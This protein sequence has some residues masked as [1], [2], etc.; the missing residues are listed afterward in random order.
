M[1]LPLSLRAR[2]TVMFVLTVL[3]VGLALIGLVYVYLRLTPVPFKAV[4]DTVDDGLAIDAAIPVSD[5]ILHFLLVTSLSVLAL[6]TAVSGFVGWFVAGL[7]IKPLRT[8]AATARDITAGATDVRIAPPAAND[9]VAE[10]AAA[11]NTMLDAQAATIEAQKRFAANASHELKTPISTI[12]AIADV[13]L[14]QPGGQPESQAG[15][16]NHVQALTRIREVNARNLRTVEGLLLLANAN[17][18][19]PLTT[20][21]VDLSALC[22]DVA[23]AHDVHATIAPH[24]TVEGDHELLRQAVDNL[25]RN[26]VTHGAPGTTTLTLEAAPA[27]ITVS[28]LDGDTRS[29]TG[30]G[31]GLTLVQAIADAHGAHFAITQ[32]DS[33]AVTS[34]LRF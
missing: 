25:V 30:H 33:G 12:Q 26:A 3:G 13:A 20:T 16:P 6:L 14:S 34:R 18:G 29:T 11:L 9:E 23:A 17:S 10:V 27:T 7:V 32:D 1:K 28:N 5:E 24:I 8:I 22:S 2:I 15:T 31:L 21:R 4:I 19:Q